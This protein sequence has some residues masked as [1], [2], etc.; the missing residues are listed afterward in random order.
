MSLPWRERTV[1]TSSYLMG[2][3]RSFR[4]CDSCIIRTECVENNYYDNE[5]YC[6]DRRYWAE[7]KEIYN[8]LMDERLYNEYIDASKMTE[9]EQ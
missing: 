8:E 2:Q 7:L 6:L 3:K 9:E 5:E 4:D 1:I